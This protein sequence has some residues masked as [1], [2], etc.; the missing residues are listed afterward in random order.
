MEGLPDSTVL[1]TIDGAAA[2]N[3]DSVVV[4]AATR[5]DACPVKRM[6]QGRNYRKAWSTP[7]GVPSID[8]STYKGGLIP[9]KKGGV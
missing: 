7:V 6:F 8:L 3:S 2:G 1:E 4:M 5:Y 9:I